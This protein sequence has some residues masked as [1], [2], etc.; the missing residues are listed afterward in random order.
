M[1]S[2]LALLKAAVL[3][4]ALVFLPVAVVLG[5]CSITWT[6]IGL[7]FAVGMIGCGPLLWCI[8]DERC[9][10]RQ[11]WL[12][13]GLLGLGLAFGIGLVM[14]APDGHTAE[15]A[16][17]HSRYADGGWHHA[18]FGFGNV[19]PETDQIHLGYQVAM[20]FDPFFTEEQKQE[21][22]AMTDAIYAEMELDAEFAACGSALGAIYD[23]VT[24]AEFRH[25]HYFHYIPPQLD[26]TKPAPALVFLHGSG[27][28]FK[29]YTWL[30]SK[31]ADQTGCTVIAPSF[32]LGNWEKRGAYEAITAA[33]ADAGKHAAIDPARIHLMG[34][35][36]GGKGVCLAESSRGPRFASIILLSAVLHDDIQP[37]SLAKRLTNRPV[38]ILSGQ[39]DDRVPWSYVDD[40][41]AKLE[42]GGMQVT[43]RAFDGEDHFLFFRRQTEI[44]DEVRRWIMK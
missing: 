20:K 27:G 16:R 30:L 21:L 31:V 42:K 17:M 35:S 25:G 36:N 3:L 38:L 5:F 39:N 44:L 13:K 26:R 22:A 33:I 40:Y 1:S 32:G 11:V 29:A 23:E 19:L 7:G 34:L 41:A 43:K 28:N 10:T 14:Q 9:S 12:G 15:S 6:G 37:A 24:F 4:L 8:G 18:R 2:P